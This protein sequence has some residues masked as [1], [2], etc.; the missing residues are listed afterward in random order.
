[1]PLQ[2]VAPRQRRLPAPRRLQHVPARLDPDHLAEC[3][4]AAGERQRVERAAQLVRPRALLQ[5]CAAHRRLEVGQHRAARRQLA[6]SRGL[7]HEAE[8]VV[9]RDAHTA[10][11][12]AQR[13][14]LQP[15]EECGPR[16]GI[17][18][19]RHR[20]HG[21]RHLDPPHARQHLAA[22]SVAEHEVE[23]ETRR[24]EHQRRRHRH[25][26]D[27]RRDD[28]D[29]L[30]RG[31][32]RAAKVQPEPLRHQRRADGERQR[33]AVRLDPRLALQPVRHALR[34]REHAVDLVLADGDVR[35]GTGRA[36]HQPQPVDHVAG[37]LHRARVRRP[38][39]AHQGL[40]LDGQRQ[41]K[42]RRKHQQGG[43]QRP[44]N[45]PLQTSTGS[46]TCAPTPKTRL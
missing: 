32:E 2:I 24:R 41:E 30:L 17:P 39:V 4:R 33:D 26:A 20:R 25:A 14:R 3:R 15:V 28:L 34:R 35:H 13:A 42:E 1:M 43:Q 37:L 12:L 27:P 38:G 29:T 11:R 46:A 21:R 45:A 6:P 7:A 10:A 18:G 23:P 40:A 9:D 16:R 5:H 19:H 36:D 8:L 44:E 31:R 22:K